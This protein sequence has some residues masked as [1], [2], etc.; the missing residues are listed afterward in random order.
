MG[1]CLLILELYRRFLLLNRQLK[2][3]HNCHVFM[4]PSS[5]ESRSKYCGSPKPLTKFL[6]IFPMGLFVEK[7]KILTSFISNQN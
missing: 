5:P 2:K 4:C 6:K 7:L 1:R 3:E